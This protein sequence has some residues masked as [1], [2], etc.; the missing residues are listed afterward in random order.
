MSA[1]TWKIKLP[2][3][4]LHLASTL[5]EIAEPRGHQMLK[6]VLP[7]HISFLRNLA[8]SNRYCA[9]LP[10]PIPQKASSIVYTRSQAKQ[11]CGIVGR[12]VNP[13]NS[14]YCLLLLFIGLLFFNDFS[15]LCVY[16]ASIPTLSV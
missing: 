3:L 9:A 7:L 11:I 4:C 14:S 15:G 8:I 10:L 6:L 2:A 16:L 1:S 13:V 12:G 5:H